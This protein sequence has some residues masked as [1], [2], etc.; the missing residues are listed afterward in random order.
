MNDR[1]EFL[2]TLANSIASKKEEIVKSF[3]EDIGVSVKI[4]SAEVDMTVD[5]LSTMEEELPWVEGRKPYGTVG[6]ILP[7]D[8]S[9]M[10]FARICGSAVIG[11]N[12]AYVSFSSLTPGVRDIIHEILLDSQYVKIN[13]S[14]NNRDFSSRCCEDPDIAVFFISGGK[15]VGE[16]FE[17]RISCFTKIIFAGPSGMP[18]CL[19]LPGADVEK[20]ATFVARRSFLNGGQYCTTIK[21]TLVHSSLF[22]DFMD[23]LLKNV[24][25]I[26]VGDP[27]DP[28]TDYGPIKAERTRILVKR[29]LSQIKGEVLRGGVIDGEWI[30]PTVV[31]AREIPDLEMF[32]PFLAVKVFDC[33]EAMVEESLIT[34]YRHIIYVFGDIDTRYRKRIEEAYGMSHF[35]PNFLFLPLRGPYGG[36]GEAGWVLE[37]SNSNI[38]RKDGA[39]IYSQELT[40]P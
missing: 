39:I 21:R 38:I 4:G 8:A 25:K 33:V 35:N 30:P 24:D 17:K 16:L 10:M 34:K 13:V 7:Y 9:T 5:Y 1:L 3:A 15:H 27:M 23:L 2:K 12:K 40:H 29:A 36:K 18:P 32:G 19:V 11:G 6:A 14:F 26:K 20:A 22:D 28:E 31:L 37:R